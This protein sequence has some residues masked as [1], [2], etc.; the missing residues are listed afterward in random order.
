MPHDRAPRPG[1]CHATVLTRNRVVRAPCRDGVYDRHAVRAVRRGACALAPG[2][3][4]ILI[5]ITTQTDGDWRVALSFDG[6]TL[7]TIEPRRSSKSTGGRVRTWSRCR[8]RR[9]STRSASRALAEMIDGPLQG[10]GHPAKRP[11]A[12]NRR[13]RVR[14]APMGRLVQ[15]P[16]AARAVRERSARRV[17]SQVRAGQ[18]GAGQLTASPENPGRFRSYSQSPLAVR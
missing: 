6:Q 15:Q 10:R 17:R 1:R 5:Y 14:D 11:V 9:T 12:R 7:G 16:P 13:S 4:R 3:G 18:R 8:R 2:Q